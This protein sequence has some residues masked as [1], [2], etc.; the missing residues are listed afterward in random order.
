MIEHS[1]Y[2][3][4]VDLFTILAQNSNPLMRLNLMSFIIYT[5]ILNLAAGCSSTSKLKEKDWSKNTF[6]TTE[7][8]ELLYRKYLRKGKYERLPLFIFLHGAGERG[9]DNEA[10][11]QWIAPMLSSKKQVKNHPAILVFPQCPKEDYWA[12]VEVNDGVWKFNSAG[13]ATPTMEQ[14]IE[15]IAQLRND[16]KV[17]SDRIYIG[18]LS[19]GGFGTFDILSRHPELFAGAIA[20][21]G[22]G[23][24]KQCPKYQNVPIQIFHGA[25]D[26]L[27]DVQLSRDIYEALEALD[28]PVKYTEYEDGDHLVWNRAFEEPQLLD[29]LFSQVANVR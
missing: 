24:I 29:W 12:P 25:K 7:G 16:P 5:L 8:E 21:C 19:M 10:Q 23:D 6:I 20:I 26:P 15:L 18:G 3:D 28:A 9:Q 2:F 27:V 22:G 1:S 14:L 11:L 4:S 17:D 13:S